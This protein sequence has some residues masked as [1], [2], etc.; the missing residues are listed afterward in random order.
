MT[1]PNEFLSKE[2]S[3]EDANTYLE[4]LLLS[5]KR[6][7]TDAALTAAFNANEWSKEQMDL[8]NEIESESKYLERKIKRF[9]NVK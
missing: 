1:D 7:Q 2:L 9:K 4:D 3:I 5:L 6:F 8:F